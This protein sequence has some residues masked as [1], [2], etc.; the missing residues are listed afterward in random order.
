MLR[1]GKR[2]LKADTNTLK[3]I[4]IL[5]HCIIRE[6]FY[7][8]Y[9]K[10]DISYWTHHHPSAQSFSHHKTWCWDDVTCITIAFQ[11]SGEVIHIYSKNQK[12]KCK[13]LWLTWDLLQMSLPF[14]MVVWGKY[15]WE[16]RR[17][18]CCSTTVGHW[19]ELTGVKSDSLQRIHLC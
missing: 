8:Y 1:K 9:F 2:F 17:L 12:S 10:E 18:F 6:C 14:I 5:M 19:D 15:F 13:E 11:G 7:I 4:I 16:K 3:N